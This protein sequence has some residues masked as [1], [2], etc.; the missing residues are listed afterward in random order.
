MKTNQRL[1]VA[2]VCYDWEHSKSSS[3]S[4]SRSGGGSAPPLLDAKITGWNMR[5]KKVAASKM[6]FVRKADFSF[7]GDRKKNFVEIYKQSSYKCVS[8]LLIVIIMMII[9]LLLFCLSCSFS[10]LSIS[11]S[12]LL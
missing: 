12:L 8:C 1:H 9:T 2:Q 6:T 7:E 4:S 11:L 10:Y 5:D 3:S